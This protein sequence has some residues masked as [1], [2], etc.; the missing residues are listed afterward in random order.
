M[1]GLDV[2][3]LQIDLDEGLPVVV[4]LVHFGVVEQVA[5]EIQVAR[6]AQVLELVGDVD[7]VVLEQQA[8]PALQRVLD[9]F[10]HGVSPKCGA[11][12][13]SPFRS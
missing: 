2:V 3:V 6:H 8:V 9:R 12:I 11:P 10:R 5:G 4:A 7:A 13:S 1:E